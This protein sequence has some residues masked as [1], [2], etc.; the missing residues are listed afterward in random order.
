MVEG[1]GRSD[2]G[3]QQLVD[4]V[5]VVGDTLQIYVEISIEITGVRTS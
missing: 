5:V 3:S 2:A 4:Q 1:D